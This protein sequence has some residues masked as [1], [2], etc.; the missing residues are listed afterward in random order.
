[1]LLSG[2]SYWFNSKHLILSTSSCFSSS[3]PSQGI[4]FFLLRSYP[5][6]LRD[7]GVQFSP[8]STSLHC[9][10]KFTDSAHGGE[11]SNLSS[12]GSLFLFSQGKN[13]QSIYFL[14]YAHASRGH[15]SF[16]HPTLFTWHILCV[17]FSL[18]DRCIF[19]RYPCKLSRLSRVNYLT[20]TPGIELRSSAPLAAFYPLY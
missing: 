20:I 15:S 5:L 10:V 18:S 2:D 14:P 7:F 1:M 17:L 8:F 12:A 6:R 11:I 13:C 4:F 3:G 16:W 19:F 9:A